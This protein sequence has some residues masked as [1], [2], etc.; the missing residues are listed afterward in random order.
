MQTYNFDHLKVLILG[1]LILD[2]YITGKVER[3][4]PEAPTPV[5]VEEFKEHKLGGAANVALNVL[6]LG[7][8][9]ALIGVLGEDV[10]GRE[11]E[12]LLAQVNIGCHIIKSEKAITTKKSRYLAGAQQI[13]RVDNDNRYYED[14]IQVRVREIFK[15]NVKNYDV[16]IFSDYLKGMLDFPSELMQLAKAEGKFVAVDSKNSNLTNF[17]FADLITPNLLEFKKAFQTDIEKGLIESK[18]VMNFQKENSVKYFLLSKGADGVTAYDGSNEF[19]KKADRVQVSN[20]TGAGDTLLAIVTLALAS[21]L[22]ISEAAELGNL[23]AGKVVAEQTTGSI[24]IDQLNYLMWR[25]GKNTK[26]FPNSNETWTALDVIREQGLKIGFT[27][28]C[29]DILH[30]GHIK[31]LSEVKKKVDFLVVGLNSDNS[32]K[33]LKGDQRPVNPQEAR[34]TILQ[35]LEYVDMVIVFDE[36]T[37]EKL[38]HNVK[39]DLLA[40]GGD[41]KKN[42]ICG[43]E[44]MVQRNREVLIIDTLEG[45]STTSILEMGS[46]NL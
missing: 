6:H 37:P 5:F 36:L 13:L 18:I 44:F 40:K 14:E 7:A 15:E 2:E 23:A 30:A 17:K 20:V 21:N 24:T 27:N 45:Y 12:A 19:S 29:F 16:V 46:N 9:V 25:R 8:E 22:G 32:V 1:D 39:P 3:I 10:A 35:S 26:Y 11:M 42:E 43:Y 31:L 33:V 4:S 34:A 41:Y 28:G 38:I